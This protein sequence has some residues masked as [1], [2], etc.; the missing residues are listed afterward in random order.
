MKNIK[1][2]AVIVFVI[3]NQILLGQTKTNVDVYGEIEL[4]I[5]KGIIS[6]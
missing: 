6:E 1:Y 3:L 2:L 4:A 5:K